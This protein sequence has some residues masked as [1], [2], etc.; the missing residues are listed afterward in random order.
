[1][2]GGEA[3][4]A[5]EGEEPNP[6]RHV[7]IG[8]AAA[9]AAVIATLLVGAVLGWVSVERGGP[10]SSIA[11]ALLRSAARKRASSRNSCALEIRGYPV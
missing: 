5:I 1:M 7:G 3:A 6:V 9:L 8:M 11:F 2:A 10:S 4:G